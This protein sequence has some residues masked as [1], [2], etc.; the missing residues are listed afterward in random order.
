MILRNIIFWL[1]ALSF[2]V[3]ETMYFFVSVVS[4]DKHVQ[5]K[6]FTYTSQLFLLLIRDVLVANIF[7]VYSPRI[8]Q[9]QQVLTGS[10]GRL[11][12]EIEM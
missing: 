7:Y 6:Y 3:S 4:E 1:D 2:E 8:Y 9:A 12:K 5:V 10:T 11:T